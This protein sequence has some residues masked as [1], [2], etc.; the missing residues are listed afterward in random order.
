MNTL[1]YHYG[2][3]L[4]SGA[5][6][7]LVACSSVPEPP[8]GSENVRRELSR[9]QAVP[10]LAS[11]APVAIQA[12]E[13]SVRATEMPQKRQ[14]AECT[15]ARLAVFLNQYQDRMLLIE[16]HTDSVGTDEFNM[17]SS[18]RRADAV[19]GYLAAQGVALSR[20]IASGKGEDMPVAW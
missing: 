8:A 6:L 15:L 16:G 11:R 14:R 19:I 9:L 13:T 4:A 7:L 12:A 10:A 20:V 17:E 1:N 3:Q 5:S 18:Q 2:M